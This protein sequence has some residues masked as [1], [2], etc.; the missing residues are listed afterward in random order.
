MAGDGNC[1]TS[2]PGNS[3]A[4]PHFE[5]LGQ[6]GQQPEVPLSWPLAGE[7]AGVLHSAVQL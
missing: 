7:T 4:T 3:D 5:N 2:I 1:V 6:D